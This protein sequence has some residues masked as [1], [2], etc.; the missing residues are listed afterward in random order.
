MSTHEIHAALERVGEFVTACNGYIEMAAPWK[1]AKDPERAEALDHNDPI[2]LVMSIS[3][4]LPAS[5]ANVA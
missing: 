3:A 5:L 4:G 1:L 2:S